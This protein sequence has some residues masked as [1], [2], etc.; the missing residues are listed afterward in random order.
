MRTGTIVDDDANGHDWAEAH[1]LTRALRGVTAPRWFADF[2]GAF[3]RHATHY[4]D[5][6]DHA[7]I[8]DNCAT[9]LADAAAR[10]PH[11]IRTGQLHLVRC[12]LN[13]IPFRDRAFDA[14]L[15][16]RVLHQL[17]DLPASLAE[18]GRTVAGEWII[19]VPIKH[20]IVGL[21]RAA[22][23]GQWRAT[24]GS[25]PIQVDTDGPT[26]KFQLGAVRE[27][28]R[29]LGWHPH[30]MASVH[31]LRRW[32][33]VRSRP[34]T[35]GLR[36]LELALQRI[37]RGWWGPSQLLLATRYERPDSLEPDEGD[38]G[39]SGRMG[40]PTCL[41]ALIWNPREAYCAWC[42]QLFPR[43][44]QFWDF[45]PDTS[46]IRVRPRPGSV[47][48]QP[49]GPLTRPTAPQPI[50]PTPGRNQRWRRPRISDGRPAP[51]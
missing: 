7:V 39:L 2:G 27:R 19:D 40:C 36:P 9:N 31:N 11:F 38:S 32:D 10:Y 46:P 48:T 15:V 37:G 12:D 28:L 4:L 42:R 13:A 6:A 14:A 35:W 43:R 3:G 25:A 51:R 29:G 45:V 8:L 50:V 23:R 41:R 1:A 44:G 26:W 16:V 5:R 18:M 22:R 20:H 33:R 17:A 34:L 49:R 21:L 24:R 30:V 47:A